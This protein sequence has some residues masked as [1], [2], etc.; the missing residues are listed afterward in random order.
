MADSGAHSQEDGPLR[1]EVLAAIVLLVLLL[2]YLL[3]ALGAVP[4]WI[5][6]LVVLWPIRHQAWAGRTLL[7]A[8]FLLVAWAIGSLQLVL[9]PFLTA[10]LLAYVLDPVVDA[11]ERVKLPRALAS[12][13]LLLVVFA[14]GSVVFVVLLPPAIDGIGDLLGEANQAGQTLLDLVRPWLARLPSDRAEEVAQEVLPQLGGWLQRLATTLLHGVG[15]IGRGLSAAG[16]VLSFV[17]ITP[18][19]LFY[20]LVDIDRMREGAVGLVPRAHRDGVTAFLAEL[21]GLVAAYFRGQVIVSLVVGIL[22]AALLV[23]LGVPYG[24]AIGIG[25]GLLNLVPIVGFWIGL[26]LALLATLVGVTPVWPTLLWVGGGYVVIQQI[27]GQLLSPRIVGKE[28]GLPPVAI[29]MGIVIFGSLFGLVGVLVAV[30]LTAVT[31]MVATRLL[32]RYRRSATFGGDDEDGVEPT[33]T[34]AD[35]TPTQ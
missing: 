31:R 23:A 34:P 15:S 4:A 20:L 18:V 8:T 33:A 11:L 24:V 1:G 12:G 27:E 22:T 32:A 30:P 6:L 28:V 7:A 26:L 9:A 21:D 5:G 2:H 29:L 3:P 25:S 13:L 19:L 10:L 16:Q 35:E 17:V 14:L